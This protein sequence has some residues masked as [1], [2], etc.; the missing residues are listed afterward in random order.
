[1]RLRTDSFA[2]LQI[3]KWSFVTMFV[4]FLLTYAPHVVLAQQGAPIFNIAETI[5][6]ADKQAVEGDIMTVSSSSTQTLVRASKT[7]DTKMYGVLVS[8]PAIVFRT[9]SSIPVIRSG[10]ATVN[11]SNV[12]GAIRPGDYITSSTLPG[13]GMKGDDASGFMLG[14]AM[15]AFDGKTGTQ[16]TV[17]GKRV[18]LGKVKVSVGIGPTAASS[19]KGTGGAIQTL[20]QLPVAVLASI[21]SSKQL[22]KLIRYILAALIALLSIYIGFQAFGKN[23][24]KGIEAIG[25]NPLARLPIESM[26]VVNV[27]LIGLVSIGGVILS[28]IVISL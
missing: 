7:Y 20:K 9:D 5:T 16:Q 3:V 17:G 10:Q 21:S 6:V 27:I 14:I 19:G 26:I 12:N 18:T 25:R 8:E 28:L 4:L 11:V 24:T 22:E 13:K 1:M 15:E 2:Q 23:V